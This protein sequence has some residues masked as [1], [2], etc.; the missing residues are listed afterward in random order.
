[1]ATDATGTPTPLGI[2]TYNINVDA[3]SGNGNTAQMQAIDALLQ[4]RATLASPAF[5][6][7][8][9][10]PTP[11][12][13]DNSTSIATTAFVKAQGYLT[14]NAVSTVF[15]RSGAVVANSGDYSVGQVT[16]AA[17]LNS[18]AFTG[19]P[20]A[21]TPATAD[22][23]TAVATTAFVKA[24]GYLT[25]VG[26]VVNTFNGRSGAV[27]PTSGDYTAAQVT[28]AADKASGSL[29]SFSAAI[30]SS[31][32]FVNAFTSS[33]ATGGTFSPASSNGVN[34]HTLTAGGANLAINALGTPASGSALVVVEV[35]N[36]GASTSNLVWDS[37]YVFQNFVKPTTAAGGSR[38]ALLFFYD[39]LDNV[40]RAIGVF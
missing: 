27:S 28:N 36:T 8:P 15:G 35:R 22:N 37:S 12:T 5:T 33:S 3:P 40:W 20:T 32:S 23:S 17:P 10:A 9:T 26:T 24:Q 34:I 14:S 30:F 16:G 38:T 18:P 6:G 1:M 21:P 19:S 31:N 25:S 11:T 13:G 2:P 7:T 4:A 29:Q 39:G